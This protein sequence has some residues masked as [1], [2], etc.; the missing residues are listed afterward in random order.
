MGWEKD[1]RSL[2]VGLDMTGVCRQSERVKM[3]SI[4]KRWE[5]LGGGIGLVKIRWGYLK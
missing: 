3:E 4:T 5:G 1:R 2:G